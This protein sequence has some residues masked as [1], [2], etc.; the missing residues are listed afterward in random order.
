MCGLSMDVG[1]GCC[2]VS[3]KNNVQAAAHPEFQMSLILSFRPFTNF[4][5]RGWRSPVI[6]LEQIEHSPRLLFQKPSFRVAN[7]VIVENFVRHGVAPPFEVAL[8][9]HAASKSSPSANFALR[10][11]GCA[12]R[13]TSS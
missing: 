1:C 13:G 6:F 4:L 2:C 10:P 7:N 12:G 8:N 3:L 9:S 11:R 5:Q